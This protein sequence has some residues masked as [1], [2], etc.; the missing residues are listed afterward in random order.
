MRVAGV[1]ADADPSVPGQE[2]EEAGE[3]LPLAAQ[4]GSAPGSVL[5]QQI[6]S[7]RRARQQ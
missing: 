1:K 4:L 2:I 6:H 3:L 5:Q 7:V